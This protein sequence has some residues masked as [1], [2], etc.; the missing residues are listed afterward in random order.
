MNYVIMNEKIRLHSPVDIPP[1]LVGYSNS[2]RD[3][4]GEIRNSHDISTSLDDVNA[5]RQ[6]DN[7]RDMHS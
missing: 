7:L 5:E 2:P 3:L 6:S 1:I 4:T